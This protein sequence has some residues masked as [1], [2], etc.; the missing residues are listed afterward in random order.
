MTTEAS[1]I[2]C[3]VCGTPMNHH[4]DKIVYASGDGAGGGV[5][6]EF[7]RCPKCGAGDMRSAMLEG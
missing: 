3:P 7:Y 6:E 2:L 4:A 5:L 1:S